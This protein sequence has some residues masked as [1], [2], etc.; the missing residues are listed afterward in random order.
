MSVDL[1][2][3]ESL[4]A[5]NAKQ[6]L[7]YILHLGDHTYRLSDVSIVNSPTPVNSPTTRGGVYFSDTFAYKIKGTI[8]DLSVIPLLSKTMLGPNTEFGEIK[9][10][11]QIPDNDKN[12]TLSIFTNLTNSVQSS[13]KIELNM[14]LVKLQ[15]D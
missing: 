9:I 11:T 7:N 5:V 2:L 12:T 13:S 14:I 1:S 15:S 10:T 4:M 3:L 8:H 6:S